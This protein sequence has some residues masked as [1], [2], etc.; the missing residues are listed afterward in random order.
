MTRFKLLV[1]YDGRP[2]KGW[3]SQLGAQ[4]VQDAIEHSLHALFGQ[5][6]IVHGSGRTDAGV[7]ALGQ[8]AHIDLET[9]LTPRALTGAIN[10]HL[11]PEVRILKCRVVGE[12]FHARFSA[13]GKIY[14]YRIWNDP[15]QSPFEIG[16]S[17][18]HPAALDLDAL[19]T[20]AAKLI[21]THDFA[22]F[23]ANRGHPP[24]STVRTIE[25]FDVRRTGSLI[26]LKV[27]GDGFLY[28]MVRLMTGTIVRCAQGRAAPESID[29]LLRSDGNPK[30]KFVAP[31]EGL[32]LSRVLY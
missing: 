29:H 24:S 23:A 28:K 1:A 5:R 2:F 30:T 31:A 22:S 25:R 20:C 32:Y 14:L 15:V 17:W 18:F 16:R 4:T 8:C 3:Q 9:G 11:P 13:K 10:A 21:G 26:T 6:V 19:R 7:H 27:Q 12:S